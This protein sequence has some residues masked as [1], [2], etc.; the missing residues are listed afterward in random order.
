MDYK[1]SF[2]IKYHWPAVQISGATRIPQVNFII[3]ITFMQCMQAF[4]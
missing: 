3:D 4:N 2:V 1:K